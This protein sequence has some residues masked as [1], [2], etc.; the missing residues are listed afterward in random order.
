MSGPWIQSAVL[1]LLHRNPVRVFSLF[2]FVMMFFD[3]ALF[4]QIP[5]LNNFNIF[6]AFACRVLLCLF[7]I[8]NVKYF[9]IFSLFIFFNKSQILVEVYCEKWTFIF[10]INNMYIRSLC[11]FTITMLMIQWLS[12]RCGDI[13]ARGYLLFCLFF[14]KFFFFRCQF[15]IFSVNMYLNWCL[16]ARVSTFSTLDLFLFN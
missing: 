10:N 2:Y 5:N 9:V 12:D 6:S 1:Y 8:H 15:S 7:L 16:P 11:A 4:F 3:A 14:V 13:N